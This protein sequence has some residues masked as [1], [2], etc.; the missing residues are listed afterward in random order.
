MIKIINIKRLRDYDAT[1]SKYSK[2]I[3]WHIKHGAVYEIYRDGT[4]VATVWLSL[5]PE[6]MCMFHY[7]Y[8]GGLGKELITASKYV[9]EWLSQHYA[10]IFGAIDVDNKLSLKLARRVGFIEHTTI[11]AR[12]GRLLKLLVYSPWPEK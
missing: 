3:D 1:G 4:H 6:D 12:N 8:H 9:L 11:T 5:L 10:T 2:K 7:E